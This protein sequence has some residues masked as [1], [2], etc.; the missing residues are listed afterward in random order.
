MGFESARLDREELIAV[1]KHTLE[2]LA[3]DLLDG[4]RVIVEGMASPLQGEA[5]APLHGFLAVEKDTNV[6]SMSMFVDGD[7]NGQ[8]DG[9]I[10]VG[11]RAGCH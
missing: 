6:R 8:L 7:M 11:L 9:L 1:I 4:R 2:I 10:M 3:A 5:G